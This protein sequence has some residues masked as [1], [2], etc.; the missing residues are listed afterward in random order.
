MVENT[1]AITR[2][3]IEALMAD[4]SEDD[5]VYGALVACTQ[6][7][8]AICWNRFAARHQETARQRTATKRRSAFVARHKGGLPR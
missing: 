4:L 7:L 6:R 5:D 3:A 1:A 2:G 8:N